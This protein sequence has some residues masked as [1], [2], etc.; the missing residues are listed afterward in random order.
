M[1]PFDFIQQGRLLPAFS[2]QLD[3]PCIAAHSFV[4]SKDWMVSE[5]VTVSAVAREALFPLRTASRYFSFAPLRL[6]R[7]VAGWSRVMSRGTAMCAFCE[8][9]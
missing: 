7:G 9:C 5:M 8:V 3:G 4:T 2:R 6:L 1:L